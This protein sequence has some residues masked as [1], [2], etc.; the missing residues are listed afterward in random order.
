MTVAARD[1]ASA[2]RAAAGVVG[3]SP[4]AARNRF[5]RALAESLRENAE[6]IAAANEKDLQ[7]ARGLSAALLERLALP[8]DDV[9]RLAGGVDAVAAQNDP[10][11]EVSDL[12]P[13]P[14]GIFVGKMRV[15]LG[16]ILA[17]YESRPGVTADIASLAI[18]SGNAVI[19]RGGSEARRSNDALA[20]CIASALAEA[21]LPAAAA[22]V[23]NDGSRDTVGELLRCEE[24]DLVVPRGGRGLIERVA[25]EA[26]MP[27]LKHLDG[28]CHLY[29]DASADLRMAR[30]LAVNGKTRR[31]GVCNA[32]ESLLA[33]E[34][35]AADA[36]PP[37]A[38]DLM[39]CGVEIRG[40]EKTRAILGE[41]CAAAA[42]E[43]WAKEYL[44]PVVSVRVVSSLREAIAHINRYGSGHTDAIVTND[45]S[46]GWRFL[47]EVD[48]SS[49]M[50]NVSTVFADGGEYGLGAEVGI[51]TD[52]LHAR[53]PVGVEGLTTQKY[54]VLGG[55]QTRR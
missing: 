54:V 51:S 50:V 38:E 44:A 29:I 21:G 5:L 53:G 10:V 31:Y 48:S 49:V 15:P 7:K 19:L 20:Q 52:K 45:Q 2:A 23:V 27:S 42:E 25:R 43:D 30:K 17:V 18:K 28:N 14:S 26:V 16:V 24:I 22:T 36:L 39:S 6:G 37:I 13:M 34:D 46:A 8:A 32:L 3:G 55:G 11:G 35:A 12:R 41:K 9:N 4:T 33:H 47:R 40:C 1:L